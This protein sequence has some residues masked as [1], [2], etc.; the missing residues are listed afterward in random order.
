MNINYAARIGRAWLRLKA[1][2]N[3]LLNVTQRSAAAP[4]IE[5]YG[6]AR[7][8][9]VSE[10]ASSTRFLTPRLI[11]DYRRVTSHVATPYSGGVTVAG[12]EDFVSEAAGALGS[13]SLSP[14]AGANR[15]LP[16][17]TGIKAS[18]VTCGGMRET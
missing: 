15:G 1:E 6:S 17:N 12:S 16:G 3:V 14:A 4:P 9:I 7:T 2:S 13:G 8:G 11:I 10:T 5:S 18:T